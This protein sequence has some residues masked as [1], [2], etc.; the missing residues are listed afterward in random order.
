MNESGIFVHRVVA[1]QLV[2]V[3]SCRSRLV[4]HDVTVAPRQDDELARRDRNGRSL[5]EVQ[6][7][8]A[9]E[10]EVE[11][12]GRVTLDLQSPRSAQLREAVDG[13]VDLDRAQHLR[14][15]V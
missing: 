14:D 12:R 4:A 11:L 5:V 13:A 10:D 9:L 1:K 2:Q 15:G 6:P 8:A 3:A 7:A